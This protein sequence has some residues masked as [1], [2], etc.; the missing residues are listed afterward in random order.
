VG[1]AGAAKVEPSARPSVSG[2]IKLIIF[3]QEPTRKG[4]WFPMTY[5]LFFYR[6]YN[7][8]RLGSRP[9]PF[10]AQ[11]V[12]GPNA[13]RRCWD[14]PRFCMLVQHTRWRCCAEKESERGKQ[15]RR[16][17]C[18]GWRNASFS[19]LPTA[20]KIIGGLHQKSLGDWRRYPPPTRVGE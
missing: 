4:E 14:V 18:V 2:Q 13:S 12:T 6:A 16:V 3:C 10:P 1:A 20:P 17:S 5:L 11:L 15:A 8:S 9:R 7:V 19:P